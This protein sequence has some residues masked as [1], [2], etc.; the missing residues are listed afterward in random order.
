M[1]STTQQIKERLD[2][3]DFIRS[4]IPLTPAG[5]NFR[6][7]CPFHKEKTPSF[8]VSPDR[9][10]W[11]CFGS[12]GEG[13]DIFKFLMKYENLEF[14]EALKI[15]AEKAGIE[16][17]RLSP[18]D[19]K[20][21]GILYDLNNLAKD[22]FRKSLFQSRETLD[23]AK[24][25]GLKKE[26]VDEFELGL[27]PHGFENL[28][29]N[30]LNLGFDVRD[31][32]R[33]G[34]VVK[35]EK[36][37]YIDRFHDRLMFP[38]HNSFGKVVAFSGRV[39]SLAERRGLDTPAQPKSDEGG[40]S[41]GQ[42]GGFVP[43]KYVNSPETPI[44][45]KSR[46]LYG[47]H[48][49]KQAIKDAQSA[50][51]VEGQMDFLMLYQDGIRNIVATSGTALTPDHLRALRRLTDNLVFAFDN[52]EAGIKATERAMDLA[53]AADFNVR[54]AALGEFKDPGEAAERA[55]G[56]MKKMIEK[57][58]PSIPFYFERYLENRNEKIEIGDLR[59]R[60]RFVL[61]KIKALASPVEQAH[62][63]KELAARVGVPERA[64]LE[65]MET[66]KEQA[67]GNQQP[68]TNDQRQGGDVKPATRRQ[69]LAERLISLILLREELLPRTQAY[70]EYF[71]ANYR[72]IL[73]NIRTAKSEGVA[74]GDPSLR[75]ILDM[76][77]LRSSFEVG[78]V[79][80]EN[81][82]EEFGN[83][84]FEIRR[85]Y[86]REERERLLATLKASEGKVTGDEMEAMLRRFDEISRM[87]HTG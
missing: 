16:L 57:A 54:V 59:K 8:I 11:H 87:M 3:V 15:L 58:L 49:T 61:Q 42:E 18:A 35:T 46:I 10:T 12:C 37:R 53:N 72:V 79:G 17:R 24:S 73:T 7:L 63:I 52:D 19:Q 31:I 43:A 5:K 76:L 9:Q 69:L 80:E 41:R 39:L 30:L 14:Y 60:I 77:S 26:T 68:I 66:L 78:L 34:L 75:T 47:L 27:A 70:E 48:K 83:L 40:D 81:I 33:A 51:L 85:E 44:F 45:S 50:V 64:V 84:L 23:Y 36:G 86:L 38:I 55:P 82:E 29:V 6:A 21:F 32:E 1:D 56:A 2:M 22:F 74:A 71:E 13:G 67:R 65:E 4:Y 20:Q 28:M 62:W 25:R